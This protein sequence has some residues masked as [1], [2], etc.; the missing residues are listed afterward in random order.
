MFLLIEFMISLCRLNVRTTL[1]VYIH[2]LLKN[3]KS[4]LHNLCYTYY[5]KT[6]HSAL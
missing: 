5:T 6:A 3:F 2:I 1:H 4:R